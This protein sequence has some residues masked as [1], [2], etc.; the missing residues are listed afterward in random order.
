[1]VVFDWAGTTVDHGCFAPVAPFVDA[2]REHGVTITADEARGPMGLEK[3]D[4]IRALLRDADIAA[5]W[6]EAH[7]APASEEAVARVFET[8]VPLQLRSVDTNSALI[9]GVPDVGACLRGRSIAIATTTGYFAEAAERCYAAAAAQGYEPDLNINPSHVREG[10][11]APWMIFRAME[12]LDVYPPACVLKVGD[13]AFDID[14][15][16]HAGAWAAGVAATG[17]QVA[18][19]AAELAAMPTDERAALVA[20]AARALEAAGAHAVVD[21]VRDVPALVER[22]DAMLRDGIPPSRVAAAR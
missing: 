4:H 8:F 13:T 2:F 16:L 3:R 6:H 5:R 7:G 14:E 1:M 19:T 18:R 17:S 11:P 9:E 22:I 20:G 21:S 12:Q 15:G 10:R